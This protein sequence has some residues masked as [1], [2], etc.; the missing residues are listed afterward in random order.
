[1]LMRFLRQV[2]DKVVDVLKQALQLPYLR[3]K[4]LLPNRD[5]AERDAF[6]NAK[7]DRMNKHF[8]R[9]LNVIMPDM[10]N[11]DKLNVI[12]VMPT[13]SLETCLDGRNENDAVV[14]FCVMNMTSLDLQAFWHKQNH[15][16]MTRHG[17]RFFFTF[18]NITNSEYYKRITL[19]LLSDRFKKLPHD[20]MRLI[21]DDYADD[22]STYFMAVW[23]TPHTRKNWMWCGLNT[24]RDNGLPMVPAM[25]KFYDERER[26][27][28]EEFESPGS[29]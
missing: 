2:G 13:P 27:I 12:A 17:M 21:A 10:D 1:M 23:T 19:L 25:Q 22:F 29:Q 20:A 14:V 3:V 11:S 7:F 24:T 15:K 28:A 18:A 9:R 26:T 4:A 16:W 5:D 6:L 8:L